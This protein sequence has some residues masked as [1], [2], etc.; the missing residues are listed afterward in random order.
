MFSLICSVAQNQMQHRFDW[1]I[2]SLVTHLDL[3]S[4]KHQKNM[5]QYYNQVHSDAQPGDTIHWLSRKHWQNKAI[6]LNLEVKFLMSFLS[7]LSITHL[8]AFCGKVSHFSKY[9][10][11]SPGA[12][13]WALP[14]HNQAFTHKSLETQVKHFQHSYF[15]NIWLKMYHCKSDLQNI[16]ST[17]VRSTF[18][19]LIIV[20]NKMFT[21]R[22]VLGFRFYKNGFRK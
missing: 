6:C 8:C 5:D 4:E 18:G 11:L 9:L 10:A 22:R 17:L 20:F 12:H 21:S 2:T 1:K 7:S 3:N 14:I 15:E 19:L 13:C 16:N